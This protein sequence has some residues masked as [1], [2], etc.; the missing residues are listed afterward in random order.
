VGVIDDHFAALALEHRDS[1]LARSREITRGNLAMLDDW[2]SNEPR[3][4]WV[5][6]SSGTVALLKY[7]L[8]MS[9]RD[10]CVALLNE[11]GVMFTPGSVLNMEGYVRIGYANNPE[12]LREGLRL[13]SVF[14]AA[15]KV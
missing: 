7:D 13:V 14:L 4:S 2:V 6:P 15:Q 9:S 10:F 3:I 1:V 8:P 5:K 11:S 12:I